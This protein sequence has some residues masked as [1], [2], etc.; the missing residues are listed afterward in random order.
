MAR[1]SSELK[2]AGYEGTADEFRDLLV[3]AKFNL[4]PSWTDE[5]MI[6]H[7]PEAQAYCNYVRAKAKI[8][9]L[10]DPFIFRTLVNTRKRA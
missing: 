5:E 9:R 7:H 6:Y 1:L 8:D 10:E 3:E 4:Y 2:N